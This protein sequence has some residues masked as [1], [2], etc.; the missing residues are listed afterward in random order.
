MWMSEELV[1]HGVTR[2]IVIPAQVTTASAGEALLWTRTRN[3]RPTNF[4]E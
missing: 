1:A 4:V 3:V 2:H